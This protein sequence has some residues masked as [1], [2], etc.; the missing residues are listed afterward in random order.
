LYK[1][2]VSGKYTEPTGISIES[3]NLLRGILEIDVPKR[4]KMSHIKG[5]SFF[6]KNGVSFGSNLE[7]IDLSTQCPYLDRRIMDNLMTNYAILKKFIDYTFKKNKFNSIRSYYYL[8]KKKMDRENRRQGKKVIL[9]YREVGKSGDIDLMQY[10]YK[11]GD[12]NEALVK[13]V[14]AEAV[15]IEEDFSVHEFWES[16]QSRALTEE[17]GVLEVPFKSNP[18]NLFDS[19]D[20]AEGSKPKNSLQESPSTENANPNGPTKDSNDEF[21]IIDFKT[22]SKQKD[23][24]K[25]GDGSP[26]EPMVIDGQGNYIDLEQTLGLEQ[27]LGLEQT[28]PDI[29]PCR[30][31][32]LPV[33]NNYTEEGSVSNQLGNTNEVALH[34]G[35]RNNTTDLTTSQ[36]ATEKRSRCAEGSDGSCSNGGSRQNVILKKKR[37]SV[38][39]KKGMNPTCNNLVPTTNDLSNNEYPR[40]ESGVRNVIRP[41]LEGANLDRTN[42]SFSNP[43][44]PKKAQTSEIDQRM[45]EFRDK[46][47]VKLGMFESPGPTPDKPSIQ[48]YFSPK[49]EPP[50]PPQ[51]RQP[52]QAHHNRN[53]SSNQWSQP[54][55]QNFFLPLP[56]IQPPPTP[57]Q[58]YTPIKTNPPIN[59]YPHPPSTNLNRTN[60]NS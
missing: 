30:N 11:F 60:Q 54:G 39:Q 34:G 13:E 9:L 14:T 49:P 47:R 35:T 19:M 3:Q 6:V 29:S 36:L 12:S 8:A 46:L 52:Q 32:Q 2:I 28:K 56:P 22:F 50:I 16:T 51:P 43:T 24:P 53:P 31:I 1:K 41:K 17:D 18:E 44:D 15:K 10:E 45:T 21:I 57:F 23:G 7:G 55:P 42:N 40:E 27:P 25:S 37:P 58:N 4:F 38:S 20:M 5:S 33:R 48:H 26:S 59:P